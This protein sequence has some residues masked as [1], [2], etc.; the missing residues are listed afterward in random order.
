MR[1]WII[2]AA[3]LVISASTVLAGASDV[4]GPA[5][6]AAAADSYQMH[7]ANGQEVMMAGVTKGLVPSVEEKKRTP[8]SEPDKKKEESKSSSEDDEDS[9]CLG[10]F[11]EMMS[12]LAL[13]S[14]DDEE[15]AAVTPTAPAPVPAPAE[16]SYDLSSRLIL[17]SPAWQ[18]N[19]DLAIAFLT[20]D[21]IELE[22]DKVGYHAGMCG[23]RAV[24]PWFYVGARIDWT[25]SEGDPKYFYT[26][27]YDEGEAEIDSLVDNPLA[28]KVDIVGMTFPIGHS[29][30]GSNKAH[31]AWSIGPG[32]YV[33][34]ESADIAYSEWDGG[35]V[36]ASGLRTDSVTKVRFGGELRLSLG[37]Y[38]GGGVTLG[39]SSG[40]SLISWNPRQAESLALD[41]MDDTYFATYYFGLTFSYLSQ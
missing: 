33:V 7:A 30:V 11:F 9:D 40:V 6:S 21:R 17:P 23:L 37:G 22:Y 32:I 29:Y 24:A 15:E 27:T 1:V 38:L 8:K 35:H 25:H 19:A 4:A 26:T 3:L 12:V 31:V 41:W 20:N 5:K 34:R 2:P 36:A 14:G 18:A 10:T 13:C 28:S 16:P 39:M